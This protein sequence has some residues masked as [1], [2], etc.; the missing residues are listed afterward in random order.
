MRNYDYESESLEII[1]IVDSG[2]DLVRFYRNS[3]G[4]TCKI[5]R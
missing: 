3:G 1:A 2:L 5:L 4:Q